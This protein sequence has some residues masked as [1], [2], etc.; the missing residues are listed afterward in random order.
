ME[1]ESTRLRR[2]G[3]TTHSLNLTA[4]S[5]VR[6]TRRR[7]AYMRTR[8]AAGVSLAALAAATE[9]LALAL[10]ALAAAAL[11][12]ADPEPAGRVPDLDTGRVPNSSDSLRQPEHGAQHHSQSVRQADMQRAKHQHPES[13][14]LRAVL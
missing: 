6:S 1:K 2:P 3:A 11:T 9:I 5:T 8:H 12:A 13:T 4:A 10:T 14:L 7:A